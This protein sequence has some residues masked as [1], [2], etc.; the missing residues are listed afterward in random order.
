[1]KKNKVFNSLTAFIATLLTFVALLTTSSA[2][3]IWFYQPK[4]P[5]C[6]KN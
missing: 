2:S 3:T 4:V 1:M 5:K 6:F